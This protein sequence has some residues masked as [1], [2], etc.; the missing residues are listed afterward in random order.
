MH[1]MPFEAGLSLASAS[2]LAYF[3]EESDLLR[4]AIWTDEEW[5]SLSSEARPSEAEYVPGLGWVGGVYAGPVDGEDLPLEF[6]FP[7]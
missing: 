3:A 4:L 2:A 7:R 1:A 5:S 6:L